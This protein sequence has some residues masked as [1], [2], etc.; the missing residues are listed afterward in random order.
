MGCLWTLALVLGLSVLSACTGTAPLPD[1]RAPAEGPH[2]VT[3]RVSGVDCLDCVVRVALFNDPEDWLQQ[4]RS[5]RGRLLLIQSDPAEVTFYGLP[6][7]QYAAAAYLDR[8]DNGRLDRWFGLLPREPVAFSVIQRRRLPP[9]FD[10][11]RF[12]VPGDSD[13]VIAMRFGQRLD[14]ADAES[15]P[16]AS[17]S[18]LQDEG[19]P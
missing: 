9:S 11:S 19:R 5:Y 7:G 8:N 17:R 10:D 6:A 14:A 2:P 12:A 13:A 18:Q 3:V 16:R 4:Q 15:V 1:A